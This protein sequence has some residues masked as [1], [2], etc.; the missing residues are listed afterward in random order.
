[1]LQLKVFSFAE[2]TI[3]IRKSVLCRDENTW[4]LPDNLGAVGLIKGLALE[5]DA[6]GNLYFY[7]GIELE[8]IVKVTSYYLTQE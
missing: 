1:M 2:S 7:G 4:K 8:V 6:R 5:L 3:V